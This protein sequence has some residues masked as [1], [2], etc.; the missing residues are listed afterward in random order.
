M[1]WLLKHFGSQKQWINIRPCLMAVILW[2]HHDVLN[3][4]CSWVIA[5]CNWT[6]SWVSIFI[7]LCIFDFLFDKNWSQT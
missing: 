2:N 6:W 5:L 7:F 4:C 3:K 1:H